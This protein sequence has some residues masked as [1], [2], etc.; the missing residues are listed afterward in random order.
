MIPMFIYYNTL[1]QTCDWK[2]VCTIPKAKN[3]TSWTP[4]HKTFYD[5]D[6]HL[7]KMKEAN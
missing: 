5:L 3:L 7:A 2:C 4:S 1:K 6:N